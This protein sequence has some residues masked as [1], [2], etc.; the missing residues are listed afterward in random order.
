MSIIKSKD[1]VPYFY[2][3]S[4]DYQVF[5]NLI[6][7]IVNVLKIN[8]DTIPDNLD[9]TK[10]N[11]LL[12]E[13]LASFV[14]YDY[15]H[16][17]TYDANRLIITNYINMIRNRGNMVGIKTS[18]ALSFNAQDDEDRVEDL[19]MFD[20]QYV[21]SEHKIAIYVYVPSYLQ[22]IRDLLEKTRPAGIPMEMIPAVNVHTSD[23][24]A[25]TDY[26][27]PELQDYDDTRREVSEKSKVG[28]S[29][30]TRPGEPHK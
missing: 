19:K 15:D 10:C 13:L 22:K 9:P 14:G 24:I 4:R 1:Y 27:N 26:I 5:L 2:R 8:I 28:F 23:G 30:V 20:V 7:L 12:L 6:D 3:N 11:Y 17:E 29:E 21:Q 25:F 16:K 18:A